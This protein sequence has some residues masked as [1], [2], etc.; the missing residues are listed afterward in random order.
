MTDTP[1]LDAIDALTIGHIE[2]VT[3]TADD[4]AFIRSVPISHPALLTQLEQ[5]ATPSTGNDGGSKSAMNSREPINSEALFEFAKI[6]SAIRD[7]C[8][9]E[10][11]ETSRAHGKTGS[12]RAISDLRSWYVSFVTYERDATFHTTEVWRWVR[13]IEA[14]LDPP[15]RREVMLPCPICGTKAW[16]D[17]DGDQHP[18]PLLIEYRLDDDKVTRLRALCQACEAVWL[19]YDAIEELSEEI[20]EKEIA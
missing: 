10:K 14:R 8:R 11:L 4:G 17:S 2:H 12:E 7:W 13:R 9:I 18:Y 16:L 1:L 5:A 3:Q 19:G 15:K 20:R 6:T